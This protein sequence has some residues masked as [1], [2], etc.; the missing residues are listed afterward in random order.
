MTTIGVN[1]YLWRAAL[2]TLSF[3]PLAQTDSNGGVIVT[4][5]YA[6]PQNPSERAK[7][8][9]A[10]L[11]RDL[12]ADALRVTAARQTLQGGQWVDAPV[13][14]A[15]VQR[16]EEI[17]LTRAR[18]LQARR[19][20]RISQSSEEAL[21]RWHRASIRSRPMPIGRKSG[22]RRGTFRARDDSARPKS[23]VLEMFPY[24]SGRIHMG[25][26]RN[27]TMGDVLAR[28]RR[29][30][31]FE[32]L[33]PMGWDAFGMPAENAAMERN[34]HPG[35]WT[36]ANIAT[37][38]AQ[39]KRLGFALDWSRE[40]AT[41]D[42][43][44]YGHEQALFLDLFEAGPRLPQAERGQLGPGRHDRARQRA[45][46]RRPR[47][48]LGR[49]WSSGASSTSGSSRS[50]ISPRSCSTGSTAL[51]QWPDKVRLMQEN[52]IGK[53]RGMRFRFALSRR[54]RRPGRAFEVF[55]TRP[56]TIFGASFAAV[57]PDHPLA[58][59]LAAERR[60][61][62][63]LHRRV[64]A[65]RHHRGRARDGGEAGLRHR[66]RGRSIRSTPTGGCRS[67]SPI[68]C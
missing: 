22:T 55:T 45:G 2:D 56:D 18:D 33:H 36:R 28:Y 34:V 7:V 64:Q 25:H 11:D 15:T 61:G 16:L 54:R 57:S 5:W 41:C 60:R 35:E 53:S 40:L 31:G 50:P 68:S 21:P 48:A 14:A 52:W 49:A 9:V 63:R 20:R 44:Y 58:L 59:A 13:T 1:A 30:K 17:I 6:N 67:T 24:P 43:D 42:P 3:A 23:Y 38:K 27:Y 51:D 37:M 4:E 8:T 10:I 46:D 29:M 26:V 12:R 19:D 62:R 66:A 65:G 32:V 39:L 47:L